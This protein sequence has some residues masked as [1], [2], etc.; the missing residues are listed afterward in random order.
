[1][2]ENLGTA[3]IQ[4]FGFFGVFGFFIYQLLSANKV[5]GSNNPRIKPTNT[6]TKEQKTQRK[7]LFGRQKE[8][9]EDVIP[10]KKGWF[11]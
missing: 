3:L 9:K 7:G 8:I 5:I 10:K 2:F 6:S 11:K 4:L 1:M